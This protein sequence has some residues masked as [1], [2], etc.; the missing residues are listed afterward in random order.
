MTTTT[1]TTSQQ[2]HAAAVMDNVCP[3][4]FG[5]HAWAVMRGLAC[6]MDRMQPTLEHC[7]QFQAAIQMLVTQLLPC[8]AC[9]ESGA[10]FVRPADI[11]FM[12]DMQHVMQRY[13]DRPCSAYVFWLRVQ[14]NRKLFAQQWQACDTN[15]KRSAVRMQWSRYGPRF[16]QLS[17]SE[18]IGSRDG[19]LHLTQ[20]I[21]WIAQCQCTRA[22]LPQWI[23]QLSA[24]LRG[25][26]QLPELADR[27]DNLQRRLPPVT[28]NDKVR[29]R[30]RF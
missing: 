24:L 22:L 1:T 27:L 4:R 5:P 9:R 10:D 25:V 19:V 2:S 30:W 21:W 6:R 12:R 15:A 16:R 8:S 17:C 26:Q 14:V 29:L 28:N 7:R 3:D 13:P 18:D 11:E 20:L 23:H